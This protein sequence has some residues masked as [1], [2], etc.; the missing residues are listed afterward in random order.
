MR[1]FFLYAT[2]FF[3]TILYAQKKT[4][5]T[6]HREGS[7]PNAI[8]TARFSKE[9]GKSGY[10]SKPNIDLYKIISYQ[11]DTTHVDTSLTV[12]KEY[13]LN[14]LRKDIF[15]LLPFA[16]E[17]QTYNVLDFG[18]KKITSFPDVGFQ[19]KQFNYLN[20]DEINYYHV[21]TPV[22]ELYFKTVM[23][24]G[25]N[26][27]AFLTLNTN[28]RTN[29]SIA[30]KGLRSLGKYINQLSSTGNFRF[31]ASY[32][33]KNQ[34]YFLRTHFTAQDIL[35]GENGGIINS[36]NFTLGEADFQTRAR[37]PVFSENSESFLK[38]NRYFI[39]HRFRI[40]K[41]KKDNQI[42]LTHQ[43]NYEHKFFEYN[44]Q[45]ISTATTNEN[46][47]NITIN[48]YGDSYVA[49]NLKDQ[50]RY[51]RMYNKI[52]ASYEHSAYG[53]F[54]FFAEDFRFN[55]YYRRVVI[56][57]EITI[58]STLSDN[59]NTLGIGYDYRKNNL[60]GNFSFSKSV[61]DTDVMDANAMLQYRFNEEN[62]FKA[63]I[64]SVSRIPNHT[65]NLF[66]SNFVN[67]NWFN[68]FANEKITSLNLKAET[69]WLDAEAT[70]STIN[71]H[72]Y[73]ANTTDNPLVLTVSPFQYDK[74]ITYLSVKASKEIKFR[75]FALDNT[76]LFQQVSQDDDV[77]N[78]PQI[79]TRNT[80]YFSGHFFKKALFLQTGVTLNY[81][82]S[83]YANGYNPVIG[84][85][86]VQN[87][88]K[89]GN[90]PML[91]F[92]VNAK[93]RTARIYFKAEHFNSAM[94]GYNYFTAPNYPY[95]DFMIRFGLEWNFFQ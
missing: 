69:K 13:K 74:T 39:D 47:Q 33:T 30:Y 40:N 73:F 72:L 70:F 45:I 15:G 16:N 37:I 9:K 6:N 32:S 2:L 52:G 79:V 78:V 51:N 76:V 64:T 66:Q 3:S 93:I 21:P 88:E 18:M 10:E 48:R 28:E 68:D 61:S 46:G 65:Y 35:N 44:Q 77:L 49:S 58:P 89:I 36:D 43:F 55:H 17:G 67:Y 56:L 83:Y 59:I 29:F 94:T 34:R 53:T 23:E 57:P 11:R 84:E 81:F 41:E 20:Y 50:T 24:Q 60:K 54:S 4:V 75:K 82:T 38:G 80:L 42:W 90:F 5:Q 62:I 91:D 8:D 14:Y 27:D 12:Q 25:Q 19:A 7:N 86:Y 31:G 87:Q 26:L 95:R 71:D 85:L 22:T 92:F 1:N 63:K